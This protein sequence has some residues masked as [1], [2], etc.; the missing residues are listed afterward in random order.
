MYTRTFVGEL[1]SVLQCPDV[2]C[3]SCVAVAT[4]ESQERWPDP[5]TSKSSNSRLAT[6]ARGKIAHGLQCY[7]LTT[8]HHR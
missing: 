7:D 1:L 6:D 4:H 5:P 8:L 3:L 2:G